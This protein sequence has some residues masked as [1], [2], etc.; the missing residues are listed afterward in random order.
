MK[1]RWLD[2]LLASVSYIL[3]AA[4]ASAVTFCVCA[5]GFGEPAAGVSKLQ[6][7]EQLI[8]EN[9]IGEVDQTAIEDG[10]AIGM[11]DALGDPW[12]YYISAAEYDA[13]MEQMNNAYV[14]IGVT[15]TVREDEQGFDVRLVEPGGPALEAGVLPGD[16]IVAVEGEDAFA[17]GTNGAR[18]KIRGEEG[19]EVTITVRRDGKDMDITITRRSIQVQVAAG[20]MLEGNIGYVAINNFDSRCAE[21][22]IAAVEQL[23]QQGAVA[24][25]FD[26]RNNPGGYK[27]EL[28]K[29]LDHLLPEGPLFRSL[30]YDGEETV[31]S[32][33]ANCVELPMAVLINGDS[34]S[35]AEFFA[36]ALEEYDWAVTVGQATTG[37]GYFQNTFKLSD[38]SAAALS[39]GK[40]FTPNGISLAEVGGLVPNVPVEVDEETAALIYSDLLEPEKDPQIQAAIAAIQKGN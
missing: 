2:I 35:A 4:A 9:F 33:D 28:V 26:V 1:K 40:Y 25:I 18:D 27:T 15:I 29:V 12:S 7:L 24:L 13:Y 39:M 37:K 32:S 30:F 16:I 23:T 8:H 14:G 31:D 3:V 36:A 21:E 38:G 5:G 19:T 34:Y 20:Q 10:A 22:T 6:E 11:I 17:M